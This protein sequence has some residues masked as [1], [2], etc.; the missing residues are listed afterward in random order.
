MQ[1]IILVP[2]SPLRSHLRLQ[3]SNAFAP[4]FIVVV[5]VVIANL[6]FATGPLLAVR[7]GAAVAAP[8]AEVA[9]EADLPDY[10]LCRRRCMLLRLLHPHDEDGVAHGNAG[11]LG[12]CTSH[13]QFSL[14]ECT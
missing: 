5:V 12:H 13:S 2:T 14:T 11:I 4:S 9:E 6:V 3:R 8:L 7:K 1:R 10:C